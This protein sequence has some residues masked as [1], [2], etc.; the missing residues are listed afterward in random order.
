VLGLVSRFPP[1]DAIDRFLLLVIPAAVLVDSIT[2]NRIRS[3]LRLLVAACITPVLVYKTI[4]VTD[5]LGPGSREWSPRLAAILY[6]GL[7]LTIFLVWTAVTRSALH[8][9]RSIAIAVAGAAAGSALTVMLSGYASGGQ[10][11]L[12]LA[13]SA[14]ALA[15]V[16]GRHPS[17]GLGVVVVGLFGLLADGRLSAGLTTL[18]A[19]L[20]FAS[21]L[22]ACLPDLLV[23]LPESRRPGPRLQVA[24]RVI[25]PMITVT[26]TLF[27]A[28]HKFTQDSASQP[29]EVS[30][31]DYR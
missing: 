12:A 5:L 3:V 6:M 8:S 22:L 24:L 19:A 4:Y 10:L 1:L 21:P 13:A 16:G 28:Q 31:D 7:G 30:A 17:S 9:G 18:N 27:L 2:Y 15:V 20:L 11:G 25:L 29:G 14:G 26:T 23:I